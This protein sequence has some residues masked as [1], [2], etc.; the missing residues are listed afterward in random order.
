MDCPSTQIYYKQCHFPFLPGE[1]MFSAIFPSLHHFDVLVSQ[2]PSDSHP[3]TS[4][5][6]ANRNGGLVGAQV[7]FSADT[8]TS[9]SF[10]EFRAV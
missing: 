6:A 8:R 7:G 5:G 4:G 9:Y 2:C 1:G 10:S 3:D